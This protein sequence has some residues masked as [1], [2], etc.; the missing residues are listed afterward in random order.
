[1][2]IFQSYL[3]LVQR[4][5]IS[6]DKAV[7]CQHSLKTDNI[8]M[9]LC[10][11][12]PLELGAIAKSHSL[13][14][15]HHLFISM[16]PFSQGKFWIF[17]DNKSYL[18]SDDVTKELIDIERSLRP[19]FTK[20]SSHEVLMKRSAVDAVLGGDYIPGRVPL[21][22]T[23]IKDTHNDIYILISHID[24]IVKQLISYY[25]QE[26]TP[27]LNHTSLLIKKLWSPWLFRPYVAPLAI[28]KFLND[29]FSLVPTDVRS[30]F[31]WLL[32]QLERESAQGKRI[33]KLFQG[34]LLNNHK[35][36]SFIVLPLKLELNSLLSKEDVQFDISHL[37]DTAPW[38]VVTCPKILVIHIERFSS[39][40]LNDALVVFNPE[41]LSVGDSSYRLIAASTINHHVFTLDTL[42]SRWLK[43]NH[44]EVKEV[45]KDEIVVAKNIQLLIWSKL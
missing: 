12:V 1:M 34:K 9:C 43:F 4:A 21:T 19:V 22:Y 11:G 37:I 29:E 18:S 17:P 38:S 45:E 10:C 2:K 32:N 25:P 27:L 36:T 44:L 3:L 7:Q 35:K 26:D 42:T 31:V 41:L 24:D 15:D 33:R 6:A 28:E 16:D 39:D 23:A 20:E 5:N 13:E 40:T 14:Y 8:V 30:F